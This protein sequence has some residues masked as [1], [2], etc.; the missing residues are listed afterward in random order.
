MLGGFSCDFEY[1]LCF[2]YLGVLWL[3][4]K[5]CLYGCLGSSV[6]I[7]LF[8]TRWGDIRTLSW[9]VFSNL[10]VWMYVFVFR[11]FSLLVFLVIVVNA[12]RIRRLWCWVFF[13]GFRGSFLG[14][15]GVFGN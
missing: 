7:I 14:Y 6:G 10:V 1:E 3:E 8:I 9:F 4:V 13:W 12:G 11:V 2:F 15:L 5:I